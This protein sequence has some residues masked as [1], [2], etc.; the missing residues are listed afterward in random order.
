MYRNRRG[1]FEWR[2]MVSALRSTRTQGVRRRSGWPVGECRESFTLQTY[3]VT[4]ITSVSAVPVD[5]SIGTT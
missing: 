3:F 1:T 2:R 5:Q 4:S